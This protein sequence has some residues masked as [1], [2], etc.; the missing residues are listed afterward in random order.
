MVTTKSLIL[1]H[2][3]AFEIEIQPHTFELKDEI[4]DSS[5]RRFLISDGS[6]APLSVRALY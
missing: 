1:Q 2:A 4:Q 5:I 3:L 6:D